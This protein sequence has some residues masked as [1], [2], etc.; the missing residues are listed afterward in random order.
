MESFIGQIL[1]VGF[2]FSPRNYADCDGQLVS[3]S[4]NTALFSLLGTTYGGDGRSTFALPDLR[5]RVPVHTGNGPGLSSRS[6]GQK[7]GQ[8][9]VTLTSAEVPPS[10]AQLQLGAGPGTVG[11]GA[12][13]YLSAN[14]LGETIFTASGPANPP[15]VL[16]GV[17]GGGGGQSHNNM[18]PYLVV[19]YVICLVGIFP[20]RN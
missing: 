9:A 11:Q 20:S 17:S 1:C 6:M 3:I 14:S 19:R 18:Q 2:N 7:S 10:G 4:Q 12:G 8:E 5:G 13:N 15:A 16:N